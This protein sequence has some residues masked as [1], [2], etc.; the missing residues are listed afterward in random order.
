MDIQGLDYNT[1]RA[2]LVLPEY[3]RMVQGMV[4]Q[5]LTIADRQQRQRYA[6]HIVRTMQRVSPHMSQSPATQHKYWDH[7]AVLAHFQLDIDYPY[8][9]SSLRQRAT[10]P[11]RLPYTPAAAVNHYG[12]LLQ[13]CFALLRQM[14]EGAARDILAQRVARYMWRCQQEYAQGGSS[15]EKVVADLAAAT[16]G[17]VLLTA[18]SLRRVV[19]DGAP[20]ERRRRREVKTVK[21]PAR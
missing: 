17:R 16:D 15:E 3:G 2:P 18:E 20:A 10:R 14:D 1:R 5:A 4:A 21:R 7:L 8:D 11:Q 12:V 13:R 9:L 6:E 19:A